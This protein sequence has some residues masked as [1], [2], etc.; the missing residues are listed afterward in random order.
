MGLADR[1]LNWYAKRLPS[2]SIPAVTLVRPLFQDPLL[3]N[4]VIRSV[5]VSQRQMIGALARARLAGD[6]RRGWAGGR[7]PGSLFAAVRVDGAALGGVTA[8]PQIQPGDRKK[9]AGAVRLARM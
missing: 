4:E 8:V 1:L 5:P 2:K 3:L 6:G 7:G 9:R